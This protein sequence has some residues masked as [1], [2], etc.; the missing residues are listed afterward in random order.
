V[1]VR[2]NKVKQVL[3]LI[4]DERLKNKKVKIEEIK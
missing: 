2:K 4:A 3:Q 1:A